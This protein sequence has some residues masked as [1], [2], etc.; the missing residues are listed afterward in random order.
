MKA[1]NKK[2]IFPVI[3]V[4]L[5]MFCGQFLS[6]WGPTGHRIIAEIAER[7]LTPEAK[8]AIEKILGPAPLASI[9]TW[10]DFIYSE[11]EWDFAR[12]RHFITIPD[13]QTLET[14]VNELRKDDKVDNV[15]EAVEYFTAVLQGKEEQRKQFEDNAKKHKV[16]LLKGSIEA[17]A[18]AFL[19]HFTGDV[20]QPMHVGRPG[21]YGGN[22]IQV[23]WFG[24]QSNLHRV[25][26]ANL[27]DSEN[28]N[29][30]E[31]TR[32]IDLATP[33][34]IKEYQKATLEQWTQESIDLR[35][36][37]YNY[38]H[39]EKTFDPEAAERRKRP[40]LSYQYVHDYIEPLNKRLL[41]SGLRLAGR[42]NAIFN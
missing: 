23:G 16:K 4:L 29:F 21:D 8:Q 25:W 9:A 6:A 41:K 39:I 22:A 14:V 33:E 24:E 26:D 27:I 36:K 1:K 42:L 34:I 12:S 19:V 17:S 15:F 31:Y 3:T 7:H 40:S 20:H 10:P 30:S 38:L 5:M 11:K 2:F 32:F 18:L 35:K 28:L 37:I 13:D